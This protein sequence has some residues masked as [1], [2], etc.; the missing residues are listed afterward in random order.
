[1]QGLFGSL[2]MCRTLENP[3]RKA[4]G[5]R[6]LRGRCIG[7][8]KRMKT[9]FN[10]AENARKFYSGLPFVRGRPARNIGRNLPYHLGSDSQTAKEQAPRIHP[11]HREPK[12]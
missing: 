12:T 10:P 4:E 2:S 5:A 1:M 9:V 11:K 3:F 7:A 8:E 6:S